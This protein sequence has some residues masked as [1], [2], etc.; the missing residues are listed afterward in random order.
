MAF[1]SNSLSGSNPLS[2]PSYNQQGLQQRNIANLGAILGLVSQL[3]H[4]NRQQHLPP[5]LQQQQGHS[6]D[7]A[8]AQS[9]DST[10][11]SPAA[12]ASATASAEQPSNTQRA[13]KNDHNGSMDDKHVKRGRKN[14][15]GQKFGAK[16]K[17]WV[18][19][20]FVQDLNDANVAA[21]DFCGRI[22]TRMPSDKGLPKKLS[23]HLRT[24]K[25]TKDLINTTRAIPVDGNGITYN[26]GALLMPYSYGSGEV[27]LVPQQQQLPQLQ[28]Q[29][30]HQMPQHQMQ[31]QQIQGGGAAMQQGHQEDEI[32]PELKKAKYRRGSAGPAQ[33]G[34]RYISPNFDNSPYTVLMFHRHIMKFLTENKLPIRVVN[35]QL[36]QQLIYD[37]RPDSVADLHELTG[38]F[39]TFAEV[40]RVDADAESHDHNATMAEANVVNTLAQELIKK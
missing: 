21:C 5:H 34:R 38:L 11:K 12:S 24:H 2:F 23:E 15:P 28:Q 39:V 9:S 30:S 22:I 36:F 19:T 31:R 4:Y 14:R 40:S 10:S 13:Q 7:A 32:A 18:W 6:G 37:L 35:L 16:K 27:G 20:W 25:L 3:Q 29:Q 26:P 1:F 8:A 33:F 17:L